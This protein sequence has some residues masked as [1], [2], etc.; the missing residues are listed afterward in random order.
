M[1][2]KLTHKFW[3]PAQLAT[4]TLAY[5][6]SPHHRMQQNEQRYLAADIVVKAEITEEPFGTHADFGMS[7]EGRSRGTAAI[8]GDS[9]TQTD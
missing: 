7:G 6:R 3:R 1:V 9:L 4:D 8:G 5:I 2:A